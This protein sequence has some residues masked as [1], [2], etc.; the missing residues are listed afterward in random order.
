[1]KIIRRASISSARPWTRAARLEQLALEDLTAEV[2]EFLQ[3]G[4]V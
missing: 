2:V 4:G 1:M 3:R